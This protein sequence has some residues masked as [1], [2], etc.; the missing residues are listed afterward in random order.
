[1]E[2]DLEMRG[3]VLAF[4]SCYAEGN[5]GRGGAA[6]VRGRGAALHAELS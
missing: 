2:E 3:G 4:T 1:M 5:K 6:Y